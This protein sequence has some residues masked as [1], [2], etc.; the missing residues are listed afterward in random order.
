[1]LDHNGMLATTH[2]LTPVPVP[3]VPVVPVPV[4][5]MPVV[6]MPPKKKAR[7]DAVQYVSVDG[8]LHTVP[9]PTKEGHIAQS[10]YLSHYCVWGPL[11]GPQQGSQQGSQRVIFTHDGCRIIS[12]VSSFTLAMATPLVSTDKIKQITHIQVHT[13]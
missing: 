10:P 3:V 6:P 1:M 2:S 5:P 9:L 11:T 13:S 7:T 12:N 8:Y 4:V